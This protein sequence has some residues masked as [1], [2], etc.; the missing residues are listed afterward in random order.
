MILAVIVNQTI[1]EPSKIDEVKLNRDNYC[2]IMVKI[3]FEWYKS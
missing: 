1:I 2:Y 3:Y